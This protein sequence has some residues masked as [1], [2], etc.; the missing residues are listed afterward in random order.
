[1]PGSDILFLAHRLPFPPDRGD[2]IRSCHVLQALAQLAPVHVGCFADSEEDAAYGAELDKVAQS[3]CVVR[4]SKPLPMAGIEALLRGEPVSLSAYRSNELSRWVDRML[5]G[6]RI[7]AIYVFSGQMGQFVPASWKGRLVVDLVDVDSAKFEEYARDPMP[8]RRWLF[9]REAR[10]LSREEAR[11]AARADHTLLV[12]E[13]EAELFASRAPDA[14]NI[15][16]MGN[17][18]DTVRFAPDS[19][20]PTPEMKGKGPHLLFTGQMDYPPNITA[21]TRMAREIMPLIQLRYP[22]AQFHIVGRAPTPAVLALALQS[23]CHVHGAVPDIRPWLRAADVAVAPLTL[24]RGVQ[25]KVLQAMAM[26]KPVVASPQA[27][28]GIAAEDGKQIVVA[29]DNRQFAVRTITL[30][31]RPE[32]ARAIGTAAREFVES[33]Q[34]WPAMLAELPGLMG[35]DG[36]GTEGSRNAA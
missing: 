14:R 13:P 12:S 27:A 28:T 19:V 32:R 22:Q 29:G 20:D 10:L 36:K 2:R 33:Q 7:G 8:Y 26:A 25:N 30:L 1:M 34:G 18:I 31:E 4:K 35:C 16:A 24:A 3:S 11:L 9:R 23:G 6:G 21:V 15:R 17:G 5:S